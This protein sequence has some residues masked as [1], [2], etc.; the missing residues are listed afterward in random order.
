MVVATVVRRQLL[1][2]QI[3]L[4]L[5]VIV[6]LLVELVEQALHLMNHIELMRP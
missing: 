6:L 1:L 3:D 4:L 2:C 5:L